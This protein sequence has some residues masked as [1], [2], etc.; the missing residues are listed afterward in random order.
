MF[1][2]V[3]NDPLV[4]LSYVTGKGSCMVQHCTWR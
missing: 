4:K 2:G 1:D 3:K